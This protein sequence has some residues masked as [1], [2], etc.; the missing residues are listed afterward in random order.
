MLL[1]FL[2]AVMAARK[3]QDQG[4]SALEFAKPPRY[5][6]V[7]G[8]LIVR[9]NGSGYEVKAHDRIPF[10]DV[11]ELMT[12]RSSARFMPFPSKARSTGVGGPPRLIDAI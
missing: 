12:L 2:R 1:V 6:R 8:Q 9:K 10:I 7:I 3:R 11:S 4:V 5:T